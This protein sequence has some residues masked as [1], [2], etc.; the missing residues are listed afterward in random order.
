MAIKL[1]NLPKKHALMMIGD[2]I[3]EENERIINF[4]EQELVKLRGI[5]QELL[6]IR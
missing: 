5:K 4:L 1:T 3:I 2:V 6:K